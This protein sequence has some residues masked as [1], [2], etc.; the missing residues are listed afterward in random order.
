MVF[1]VFKV[2]SLKFLKSF[3]I[4]LVSATRTK[5]QINKIILKRMR[6]LR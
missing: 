4:R 2:Y 6:G 3:F 5:K 1:T